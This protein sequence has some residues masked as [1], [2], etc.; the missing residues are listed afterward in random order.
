MFKIVLSTDFCRLNRTVLPLVLAQLLIQFQ[1]PLGKTAVQNVTTNALANDTNYL[2]DTTVQNITTNPLAD[3]YLNNTTL[4]NVT[5]SPLAN[6]TFNLNNSTGE[7]E[8]MKRYIPS[9]TGNEL[10]QD[11]ENSIIK[12]LPDFTTNGK[13]IAVF[14]FNW[15]ISLEFALMRQ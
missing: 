1:M 5:T 14:K 12:E 3:D 4:E 11:S 2:N 10:P 6:D 15:K 9:I 13:A 8:R 7:L